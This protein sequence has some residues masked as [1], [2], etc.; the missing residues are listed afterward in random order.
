VALS[1]ARSLQGLR[2]VGEVSAEGLR[3][4]PKV[5]KFYADTMHRE[6]M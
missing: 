1:R 5:L 4:D 6:K 3:A 2:I